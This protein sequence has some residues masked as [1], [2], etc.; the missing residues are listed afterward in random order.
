MVGPDR[1]LIS[2]ILYQYYHAHVTQPLIVEELLEIGVDIS[3]GQVNRI[4]TEGHDDFHREKDEILRANK[5]PQAQ[6]EGLGAHKQQSFANEA[7][8]NAV[9]EAL[10]I[11]QQRHVRIA[12]EGALLGSVLEYG[13]NPKIVIVSD[14]AGQFNILLHAL[15]WIH[16][17]R[18]INK[19]I[20]FNDEQRA[21]LEDIRTQIWNYDDELKAYK[22]APSV[23]KKAVLETRFDEIFT[24][25]TH[26]WHYMLS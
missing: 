20:G 1:P 10:N 24:T 4:I 26:H 22:E 25:K 19:L 2:F 6:L 15:C 17:E 21:A 3:K 12:T 18:T 16:A 13:F 5:L 11:T 8:W 7:E 23:E 9:L 14:D